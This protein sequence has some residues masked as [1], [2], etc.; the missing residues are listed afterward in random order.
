MNEQNMLQTSMDSLKEF[1]LFCIMLGFDG[2]WNVGKEG[3][4]E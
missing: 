1:F 3:E 2:N 4:E